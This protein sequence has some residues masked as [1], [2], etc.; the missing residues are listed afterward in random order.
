MKA[1]FDHSLELDVTTLYS[2]IYSL[3]YNIL[4]N[5]YTLCSYFY[6]VQFA[7]DSKGLGTL[8]SVHSTGSSWSPLLDLCRIWQGTKYVSF[9]FLPVYFSFSYLQQTCV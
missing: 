3:E 1:L 7:L 4:L 2:I 8:S 6:C 5:F 9:S